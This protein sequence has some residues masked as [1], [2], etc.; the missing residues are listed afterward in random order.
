M[1]PRSPALSRSSS[2]A[3]TEQWSPGQRALA[4]GFFA[5]TALSGDGDQIVGRSTS[6]AVRLNKT[7]LWASNKHFVL[8]RDHAHPLS[9]GKPPL[10]MNQIRRLPC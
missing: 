6:S 8:A 9:F 10:A 2:A 5:S 3:S 4:D 7:L 1:Y